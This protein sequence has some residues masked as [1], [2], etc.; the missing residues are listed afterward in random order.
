M[1]KFGKKSRILKNR[2]KIKNKKSCEKKRRTRRAKFYV[3]F[4]ER[5]IFLAPHLQRLKYRIGKEGSGYN[6]RV[7]Q[8]I[9][10]NR[11]V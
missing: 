3:T 6:L 7:E 1:K 9:Y 10:V 4:F 11:C 8:S 2:T 5:G